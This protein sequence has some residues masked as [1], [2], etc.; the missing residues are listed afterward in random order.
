M[1]ETGRSLAAVGLDHVLQAML[2]EY[3]LRGGFMTAITVEVYRGRQ[4]ADLEFRRN[5][6]KEDP[7]RARRE[8]MERL[9]GPTSLTNKVIL[10]QRRGG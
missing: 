9:R 6:R 7:E 5:L 2:V 3:I 1:T 8:V 10:F 4:R